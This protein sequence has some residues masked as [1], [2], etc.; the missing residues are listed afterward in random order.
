MV[1]GVVLRFDF[2]FVDEFGI[3]CKG[4]LSVHHD[5]IPGD[6]FYHPIGHFDISPIQ[7]RYMK[8]L[9]VFEQSLLD[10]LKKLPKI[11]A[12]DENISR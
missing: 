3:Y 9:P 2:D 10:L 7:E 11:K 5:Y 6:M 4:K 8:H 12:D 1:D